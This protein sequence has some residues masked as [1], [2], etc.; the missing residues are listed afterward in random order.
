MSVYSDS[1]RHSLSLGGP[2]PR[3]V[4][5]RSIARA[6][7][8]GRGFG[9][10]AASLA[11]ALSWLAAA[12]IATAHAQ[13]TE[14]SISPSGIEV[15]ESSDTDSS[16]G[17]RSKATIEW[18][19]GGVEVWEDDAG[20]VR[21]HAPFVHID[22]DASDLVRVFD[23]AH[24][25]PNERVEGA[26]VAVFGSATVEGQVDGDVVAVFGSV[27]LEPGASVEGDVVAVGGAVRQ[28]AGATINGESVSLSFL[29]M[30]WG[31][32][33][34]TTLLL[35]VVLGWALSLLMGY[36]LFLLFPDRMLRVAET[37]SH[38]TALSF[39]IGILSVP[40][41]VLSLILL[42]VTLIGIPIALVLPFVYGLAVWAGQLAVTYVL[43]CRLLRRRLGEGQPWAPLLA[44]TGLVAGFFLLATALAGP[45]GAVRTIAMFFGLAGVLLIFGLKI[46]GT[47]AIIVSKFGSPPV[48]FEGPSGAP[49]NPAGPTPYGVP[50]GPADAAPAA[51]A[52]GTGTG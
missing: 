18:G 25:H 42:M 21:V 17:E 38:R 8:A 13:R 46:I 6:I 19:N 2:A 1:S 22:A 52:A 28:P 3:H 20:S 45:T 48:A 7:V 37:S 51:P 27:F 43:G 31:F 10:A 44:G 33:T 34:T 35:C 23:D 16:Q 9:I 12:F 40:V 36:L 39:A 30:A 11:L 24:V 5:R 26:V 49:T 41:M 14:V 32:P 15:V 47:G 50:G 29:P 4:G